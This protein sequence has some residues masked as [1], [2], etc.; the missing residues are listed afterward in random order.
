[1]A[2]TLYSIGHG[3]LPGGELVSHLHRFGIDLLAD[4]RRYPSSRRHP[5]FN[6]AALA[7]ALERASIEYRH[8]GDALGGYR[9][10]AYEEYMRTSA[11]RS[12]IESLEE[13][14]GRYAAVAFMCAEKQPWQCHRRFIADALQRRGWNVRHIVEGQLLLAEGAIE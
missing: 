4:V 7:A 6:G 2:S 3:A 1:L 14:A 9:E 8:L 12:G 5:R 11:F 13:L 10:T